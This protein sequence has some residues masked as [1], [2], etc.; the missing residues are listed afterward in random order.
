MSGCRTTERAGG[1]DDKRKQLHHLSF[2]CHADDFGRH[3]LESN[4]FHD[5]RNPWGGFAEYSCDIDY[6][7]ASQRWPAGMHEPGIH[8]I[9]GVRSRRRIS[10]STMRR[11]KYKR[12]QRRL[13]PTSV[14]LTRGCKECVQNGQVAPCSCV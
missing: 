1:R 13:R 8:S 2:G 14:C 4:H 3:V 10:P 5:V 12:Y 11:E 6:I 9:C 7:P